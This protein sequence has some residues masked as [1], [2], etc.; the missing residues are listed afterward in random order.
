M[1][2]LTI[3]IIILLIL[4]HFIINYFKII[5]FITPNKIKIKLSIK[6]H[7][8]LTLYLKKNIVLI[9]FTIII[10]NLKFK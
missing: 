9:E 6:M 1:K 8:I 4:F 5:I 2:N 7:K 10:I 3:F